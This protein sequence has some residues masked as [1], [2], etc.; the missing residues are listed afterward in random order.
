MVWKRELR[1]TGRAIEAWQRGAAR[2]ACLADLRR[3]V[4]NIVG[5][6]EVVERWVWRR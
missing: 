1:A 2:T 3:A 5:E 6:M 4:R